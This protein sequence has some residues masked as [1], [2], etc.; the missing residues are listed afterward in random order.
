VEERILASQK[1]LTPWSCTLIIFRDD[2]MLSDSSLCNFFIV[3]KFIG[4]PEND[5][6]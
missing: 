2:Y 5:Y 6:E 3:L 1:D 4:Q